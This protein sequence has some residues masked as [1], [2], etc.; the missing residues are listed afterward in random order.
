MLELRGKHNIAKVYTDV[1]GNETISQIIALCNSEVYRDSKIRIMPDCHAGV[2]CVIGTTMTIK[3]AVTPNLVGVDIGCGMLTVKL[4]EKR[5]DLPALD[6]IIRK[7]IPSGPNVHSEPKNTESRVE[8]LRC[9]E[10]KAPIRVDL[11]YNSI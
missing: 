4:K 3:D 10:N 5:I 7:Y 2:G 8:E 9:I 6:S 11:A 1:I